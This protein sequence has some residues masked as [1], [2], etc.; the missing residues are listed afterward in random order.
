MSQFLK[1]NRVILIILLVVVVAGAIFIVNRNKNA[2]ATT[3]YQTA[4]IERGRLRA[5]LEAE[6]GA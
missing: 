2:S 1:R 5:S 4:K 6:V 3:Q